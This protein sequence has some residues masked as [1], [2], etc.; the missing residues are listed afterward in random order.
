MESITFQNGAQKVR[1]YSIYQTYCEIEKKMVY[2]IFGWTEFL[3]EIEIDE[4]A[5][6]DERFDSYSEAQEYLT[7]KCQVIKIKGI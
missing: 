4:E 1:A 3:G 6:T 2:L 5:L 7:D